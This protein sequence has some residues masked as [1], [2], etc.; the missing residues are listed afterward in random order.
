MS[1]PRTR[2]T[3]LQG[4]SRERYLLPQ[5]PLAAQKFREPVA[6]SSTEPADFPLARTALELGFGLLALR[7]PCKREPSGPLPREQGRPD[8]IAANCA[9]FAFRQTMSLARV[10]SAHAPPDAEH[11]PR[12]PVLFLGR[13]LLRDPLARHACSRGLRRHGAD[14]RTR[15]QRRDLPVRPL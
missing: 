2:L 5:I 10:G 7:A 9:T 3:Q 12:R 15:L 1:E 8:G 14:S 4:S 13:A 11:R 6:L